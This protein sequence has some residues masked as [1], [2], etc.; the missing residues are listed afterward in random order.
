MG[1]SDSAE[2]QGMTLWQI[3][4]VVFLLA[5]AVNAVFLNLDIGG[6]PREL[7]RLSVLVGLVILVVGV[8]RRKKG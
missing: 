7:A 6:L 4:L 8:I 5:G 2:E 1:A 3:G